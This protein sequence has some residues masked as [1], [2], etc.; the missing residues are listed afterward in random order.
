M[1]SASPLRMLSSPPSEHAS[2]GEGLPGRDAGRDHARHCVAVG[3]FGFTILSAISVGVAAYV[4]R[5]GEPAAPPSAPFALEA[6]GFPTMGVAADM[7]T[8]RA[9]LAGDDG[10]SITVFDGA[11]G[12]SQVMARP[13]SLDTATAAPF[14]GAESETALTP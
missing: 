3:V 8:L 12:R 10:V 1:N 11:T 6:D 4:F 13:G 7:P 9:P 14:A 5:A 2:A